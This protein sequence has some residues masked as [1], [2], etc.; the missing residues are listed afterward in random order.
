MS[1]YPEQP[2]RPLAVA[3]PRLLAQIDVELANE[4][5]DATEGGRPA[6][7]QAPHQSGSHC[8]GAK[9]TLFA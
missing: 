5:L 2:T 9:I 1:P 6:Q 3:L 8:S 4:K 7:L